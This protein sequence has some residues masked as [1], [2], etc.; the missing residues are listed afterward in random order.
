M[1][2][3]IDEK[4][5]EMRF[6][7]KQ[8]ESGVATSMSTLEK[9]KRSL[10]LDGAAKGLEN[11]DSA[12]KK[13]D[14][15]GLGGAVESVKLKFSALDVVAVTALAN[16]T[17]SAVNAGIQLAKS[18]SVDQV[19]AGWQKFSDK[20]T[21][22]ATL[23]AQG[24]A[25]ED[26]NNQLNRLNWFTDETSYNFTEMVANIAK[27]TATGK[28]LNE[29][30]TAM[31]G[32]ATWAALSGQNATTASRA[33]YQLSQAMGAGVMRKE[34]YKSIQNASMDTDE[35]RQKCLDAGVALGTLR[36]ASTD[37]Y[38]SLVN[39]Q[40][41][42]N[43]SQF[44]EHLTQ[45]LW[46]TSDVMMKVF[47]DYSAAVEGIYEAA[48]EKGMLASEVIDEIYT[49]ASKKGISTDEA[50]KS[51]GYSFDSFALKAFEAAQKARTFQDAIDSVKDAVSTGWMNTFE[52]LFG[53]AEKA[54]ELWTDIA[55]QL[56]DV[57]AG[58][59]ERRNEILD[60][61]MTSKWD[62]LVERISEAGYETDA[63]EAKVKQCAEAAGL[64]V[65]KIISDYGSLEKAFREGAIE[66]K[67][68]KEAL[69]L[70]QNTTTETANKIS[71]DL[72]GITDKL[73]FG[74]VGDDVK[75]VQTAL[76]ELGFSLEKFGVDGV[77]GEE[78]T[79]AIK[80]FQE[81]VGLVADGIVG[82]DTLNALKEAGTSIEEIG[83]A[84]EKSKVEID[85]LLD[86]L[87]RPS[88]QELIFDI[89]HN[90]LQSISTLLGTFR[91]AWA[92][93][94]PS[95]RVASALYNALYKV[96]QATE[97]MVNSIQNN[98][99]ELKSTF[100]GV[101]AI[102]DILGS[103]VGGAF[104]AGFE[105]LG[106]IFGSVNSN[107]LETT[108]SIGDVIVAF[109]NWLKENDS[110]GKLFDNVVRGAKEVI[111]VITK[112][113]KA[114]KDI[115]VVRKV[116]DGIS[117]AFDKFTSSADDMDG[118]M[119]KVTDWFR[120]LEKS[121]V[122]QT[123]LTGLSEAFKWLGEAVEDAIVALG[124]WFEV[125]KE[126]EGVKQL[127]EAVEN[128]VSAL[129]KL[130][131]GEIDANE[132]ARVLGNSLANILISL[133]KMA[134]QIGKDF[135]AGFANG[136]GDGISGVIS[137]ILEFCSN[138]ISAFAEALGIHSPSWISYQNAVDWW[139]GFINGCKDMLGPLMEAIQPIIDFIKNIFTS[140][141]DY[142]T[143]DFGNIEWGKIF[144]A[145]ITIESLIILKQ[146][147]GA[148][149]KLANAATSFTSM[150]SA[151]SGVL[152]SFKNAITRLS[153]AISLDFNATA[154]LKMAAAIAVLAAS[155]W[156]LCQIDDIKKAWNAVAIIFVLALIVTGLSF[157]L[158][159]LGSASLSFSAATKQLD[160]NGLKTAILQIGIALL[161]LAAVVK[162]IGSMDPKE[163]QQGLLSLVGM[164][165]GLIV[166]VA[167]LGGISTYAKDVKGFVGMVTKL[168]IA[169][170]LL[171][172]VCKL[173]G[174]LSAEEM[175]KGA[176]FGAAF[177]IFVRSI[178]TVAKS[179]GN[180]VGKVGTMVL[181]ISVAM[182]AMIGICKLVGQLSVGEMLKGAA[183][184]A[185]FV[186][187][188]R[189]LVKVTKIGKK[190]QIAK[191]GGVLLSVS[192]SLA[193]MVGVC[194]LVGMLSV[195][196]MVKGGL[197]IA[198][199]VVLI[200]HMVNI[201]KIGNDVQIAKVGATL[202]AMSTV[203]MIMAGTAVILGMVDLAS[204]AKGV[205]AVS[206]LGSIA[207]LMAH[208][209]KGVSENA[210]G[211]MVAMAVAVGLMAASIVALSMIKDTK[212][213]W[214]AVGAMTALMGV[215]TVMIYSLKAISATTI[216]VAPLIV[217]SGVVLILAGIIVTLANTATNVPAALAGAAA[218]A[219]LLAVMVGVLAV[220][221]VIGLTVGTAMLGII[222]LAALGLVLR[223]LVW[224]LAEMSG[225][226]NALSNV[227]ALAALFGALVGMLGVITVI[228]A[229]ILG[230]G[231]TGLLAILAGLGTL[232]AVA[233]AIK[234]GV[235][236][237]KSIAE[238]LTAAM[239][240]LA[241]ASEKAS[242][243]DVS[244]FDGIPELL[245]IISLIGTTSLTTGIKDFFTLGGTTMDKFQR[246]GV[247]FFKAMGE[248]GKAASEV[249]M[250]DDAKGNIDNILEI[251]ERLSAFQQ[252][253][254]GIEGFI[255]WLRGV[256]GLDTFGENAKTFF[257]AMSTAMS[258]VSDGA[259][260]NGK[261]IDYIIDTA[262]RLAGLQDKLEGIEGFIGWVK[263]VQGLDN[264]GENA[265]DFF[266]A[267][268][269]AM[270]SETIGNATYNEGAI[271]YIIE[272]AEKLSTLQNSLKGV[273][274]FADWLNR[275]YGDGNLA[276][277]GENAKTFFSA[278]STAMSSVSDGAAFNGKRIDY[279]IDTAERLAELQNSIQGVEGFIGWLDSISNNLLTFGF[280]ASLFFSAMS[281]AM[282][283]VSDG[284]AF[285][286]KRIDYTIDTAERLADLQNKIQG[287]EDFI[288]WLSKMSNNLTTFGTNA[289]NFF[290]AMAT[291][292]SSVSD[293]AAFNGKR[294]DYII[295]TAGRLAEL[296]NSIQGVEGFIG[297]LDSMS[298]N[299]GT[300]G[301]NCAT[302]FTAMS[303]AMSSLSGEVIYNKDNLDNIM[304]VATTL[305]EFQEDKLKGVEGFMDW[306]DN[307]S[308]NIGTFGIN[309]S[310]FIKGMS[311]AMS[312]L[313][314]GE[315][316]SE[317]LGSIIDF[318]GKLN[319]LQS[320]LPEEGW[321]DG[322]MDLKKFSKYIGDFGE[323][324]SDFGS[325]V[326]DIDSSSIDTAITAA[327]RIK[328]LI[329]A[330]SDIDDSG[331][332][333]FTG[334]GFGVGGAGAS[335]GSVYKIA[336]A[337]AEF[338]EKVADIKTES[339]TVA[340]TTATRLKTLI[341]G[342]AG[343][344]VSGID[345]FKVDEIA[346]EIKGYADKVSGI[347]TATVS[348]SVTSANKLK[349]LISG[350]SGLDASGVSNFRVGEIG[351][352]LKNYSGKISGFDSA[353][354]SSSITSANRLRVFI[355]SLS[356]LDTSGVGSFKSAINELATV[357]VSAVV[358]AFSGATTSMMTT[359]SNM[360]AALT[361]GMRASAPSVSSA[362]VSIITS[363]IGKITAKAQAFV[364]AGKTLIDRL[365]SGISSRKSSVTSAVGSCASSAASAI[366]G[367]HTAFYNAGSYLVTGFC[368]GISMNT[369]RATAK[370]K[371]MAKAAEEAAREELRVN[372]P[373]KVFI[374]IGSAIPE[375]FAM[376]IGMLGGEVS[377]A[378]TDM[379][380]SAI[381]TTRNAMSTVLDAIN[382]DM[383]AQPSIRPVLDLS[384]VQTGVN[385]INGML[386]TTKSL[387]VQSNLNAIGY[388]MNAMRQNGK[389]D[390][391]VSAINKL[392]D[393]LDGVGN[394]Y[395]NINGVTYDDGSNVTE[396]IGT[397]VRYA[398]IGGRV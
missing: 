1:S 257:S 148:M 323:A 146:F 215:F 282:S 191:L 117:D 70:L 344:D 24:N 376:G 308:N 61:A 359:G 128:L 237:F 218:I 286:G 3:T 97:R 342:L 297:W 109:R 52:L 198:A 357:N 192:V 57:F 334:I 76:T 199:F 232:A 240:E 213:L 210:K 204:L 265:E 80:A 125:F 300:F 136:L 53:N 159:Q 221:S 138:F 226:D 277:F 51:L 384:D 182:I 8:F 90:S 296:Q 178:T 167:A 290:S 14:M 378:V 278:M 370:A 320:N 16:I 255:G 331:I 274:G 22:V 209:L 283:S 381:N 79:A 380:S 161:L 9:L 41:E 48:E 71:V 173:A 56:W 307:V 203:I 373:S 88:G 387:G 351:S 329:N 214:T 10:K 155:I 273:E 72:S 285:N 293:G 365:S 38:E 15:S 266:S 139:Q 335:G 145:G 124:E 225:I 280:N 287:V 177:A 352:A 87:N 207:A 99:E 367:Y 25:I 333:A 390:E 394:T 229:L 123:A 47:N 149:E 289:S 325:K 13:V 197:A 73:G 236:L 379:A 345:N 7:N 263:G 34:D 172:G 281:T 6:D 248:I 112:W 251:A 315:Y 93:I 244:A 346:T 301:T 361:S 129:G 321:F 358:E 68:L 243:I 295:D 96:Q 314:E 233:L 55:N 253:L 119:S 258:S 205:I 64:D 349:T 114:F 30:V 279:I 45:D 92:E 395:N 174:N 228:G 317:K 245:S 36:K 386:D 220:L 332:S 388:S 111:K 102:L 222:S 118:A 166:F 85:D 147:A 288:D 299:L 175:I 375:G 239:E 40:G 330:I 355:S 188:V 101:I 121:T 224:V 108:G 98:A 372:S 143:D 60:I 201:L 54:T 341:N 77:I 26:V 154:I 46:L 187:F 347:D 398:K 21:S 31:E 20:T 131:S 11:I 275:V 216:S 324:M 135:I 366:R 270:S 262:E 368:N 181:G 230:S 242:G 50:I 23:V 189:E 75:K 391:V 272:I 144:A 212:A 194:K 43:K 354:V 100:E 238:D 66:S 252:S 337:M 83:N 318:A 348:S 89:I 137:S 94:F 12:A 153:K 322:K 130:F 171:I 69:D 91:E 292:M 106:E 78:T 5:V 184:A 276:S 115:P 269:T 302:F 29:S 4:V 17:N 371:A 284:A 327:Y 190:Q 339:V 35:F 200:K 247:A 202:I 74:S 219:G 162:I 165:V 208:G 141:W 306:L 364:N 393:K 140:L 33:M 193:L 374:K 158:N 385:A 110:I 343:I 246:D 133:P 19:A 150:F 227:G 312:A 59:G 353:S 217:L 298:S 49:T 32:I 271:S 103:F 105:I 113:I 39:S 18:L 44:A 309:A 42:F 2:K 256:Q 152:T 120:N 163:A 382:G 377:G 156:L 392:Y 264:F 389:N 185:A 362:A 151:V 336:Q 196:E 28:G 356:G 396:A 183:F 116:I 267:M 319:D 84:S 261:R 363:T 259:A 122:V 170:L 268:S 142:V 132:F 397:L 86:G 169:M 180:N 254:I 81:S 223:E 241:K 369:W 291:S 127:V 95:E 310:T 164:A 304:S 104:K 235:S 326:V 231:G 134:I 67:F 305:A 62:S 37:T 27:F 107:I 350:L 250:G 313:G 206:I 126:T 316:N 65:N 311:T 360:I 160:I 328:Y 179:A 211:A 234:G 294:I 260:F 249:K 176:A 168:S 383:D 195:D 157:A 58:G 63:F 82:K 186:I 338:S 340:V 303:T